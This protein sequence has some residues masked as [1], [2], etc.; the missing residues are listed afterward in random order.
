M[1]LWRVREDFDPAVLATAEQL[2][3]FEEMARATTT[4]AFAEAIVQANRSDEV[5][6]TPA[7]NA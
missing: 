2:A 1:G 7:S 3:D 6:T 4:S 5:A